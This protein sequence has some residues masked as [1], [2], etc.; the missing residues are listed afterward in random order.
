VH[1]HRFAFGTALLIEVLRQLRR[2]I[3]SSAGMYHPQG[4]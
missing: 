2:N 1:R 4:N 3:S